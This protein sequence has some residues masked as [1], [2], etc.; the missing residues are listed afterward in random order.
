MFGFT[1]AGGDD[2]DGL[3]PHIEYIDP[4]GP[5]YTS[6]LHVGDLII[7]INGQSYKHASLNKVKTAL[8]SAEKSAQVALQVCRPPSEVKGSGQHV[9]MTSESSVGMQVN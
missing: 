8:R 5:A 7:S 6:G 1:V 9:G 4:V 3:Q 2:V